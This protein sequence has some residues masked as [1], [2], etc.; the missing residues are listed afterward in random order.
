VCVCV[1]ALRRAGKYS[2]FQ[3]VATHVFNYVSFKLLYDID[4]NITFCIIEC[5]SRLIKV[6]EYRGL[7]PSRPI[8]LLPH[9]PSG[10]G[11]GEF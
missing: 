5:I 6:T 11:L 7:Y 4:F 1:C 10:C 9:M 8:V 3:L 2:T